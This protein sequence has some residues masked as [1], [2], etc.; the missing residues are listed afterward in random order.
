MK[1]YLA[2]P[3]FNDRE[4]D[5]LS[6]AEKILR[7]RGLEVYSP[8]EHENREEK[9][10]QGWA[11]NVFKM[12]ITAI[13]NADI[14]VAM[15]DGNYSDSGTAWECGYTYGLNKPLIAVHIGKKANLM[16]FR[17]ARANISIDEL[18]TYDFESLPTKE[19]VGDMI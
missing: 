15:Y 14:T 10:T 9:Y 17:S 16:I 2:S 5:F 8:R 19:Y 4:I 12:D 7:Q 13:Q 18:A 3:F 1:I 6:R 11:E